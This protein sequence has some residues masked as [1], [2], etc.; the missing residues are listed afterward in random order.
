[1]CLDA[2]RAGRE[3]ALHMNAKPMGRHPRRA[4]R[5]SVTIVAA[6]GCLRMGNK[7]EAG[8]GGPE[9]VGHAATALSRI[10]VADGMFVDSRTGRRFSP[11]GFNFNRLRPHHQNPKVLWHD[12]FNPARYDR[13]EVHALFADI[14]RHGFNVVRVFLDHMAESRGGIASDTAASGLSRPYVA[15]VVDFLQQARSH[16]VRVIL[17]LSSTPASKP[18]RDIIKANPLPEALRGRVSNAN[19]LHMHPGHVA[20]HAAYMAAVAEQIRRHDP[21]LLSI[22]FAY[23]TTNEVCQIAT[24][25]PFSLQEGTLEY[26]GRTYDMSDDTSLQ[27]LSDASIVD[28]FDTCAKAVRKVDPGA[29]VSVNVFTFAA[30]S[31]TGPGHLLRDRSRD[32][33]FPARPL[34]LVT[35]SS[36]DYLDIHLYMHAI[37]DGSIGAS[38]E[39]DLASIEFDDVRAAAEA[40]S[41]PLIMGEFGAFRSAFG[42]PAVSARMVNEQVELAYEA[43]FQGFLYWTYDSHEQGEQLFHAKSGSGEIFAAL[44]DINR[45]LVVAEGEPLSVLPLGR[46]PEAMGRKLLKTV[47]DNLLTDSRFQDMGKGESLIHWDLTSYAA[48][49]RGKATLGVEASGEDAAGSALRVRASGQTTPASVS[50]LNAPFAGSPR[51]QYRIEFRVK[52]SVPRIRT[53][54]FLLDTDFRWISE[55]QIVMRA[56][57]CAVRATVDSDDLEPGKQIYF[58][59]DVPGGVDVWLSEPSVR[60]VAEN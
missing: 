41:L 5:V 37:E 26:R 7:L 20:A 51:R 57:W 49:G 54:F 42:T 24:A 3:R 9:A 4:A 12:N 8:Q 32:P 31:R 15:H 45:R 48:G 16:G 33:R 19:L 17:C 22:V 18:Y 34:T 27:K 13:A 36:V 21:K 23:E 59:L 38:F 58:R 56:G 30:V 11:R 35:D 52:A 10:R 55:H 47:G 6:M 60:L 28:W 29:M 25:P 44:A 53:R 39:D 50:L 40:R 1:M 46:V 14:A 43:G 2:P